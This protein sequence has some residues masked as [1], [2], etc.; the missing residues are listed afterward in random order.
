MRGGDGGGSHSSGL[1][2]SVP[3]ETDQENDIGGGDSS[4]GTVNTP[5]T[6]TAH[7]LLQL[8][9]DCLEQQKR[10][11]QQQQQGGEQ[12][13]QQQKQQHP[14]KEQQQQK[15]QQQH[16]YP[17]P[18]LADRSAISFGVR[19]AGGPL[20][21]SEGTETSPGDAAAGAFAVL[22]QRMNQTSGSGG[23]PRTGRG[24]GAAV[25]SSS[26][27]IGGNRQGQC[28]WTSVKKAA[29]KAA[30]T[31]TATEADVTGQAAANA[32]RTR[33]AGK[34]R[35]LALQV[36][37]SGTAGA[38]PATERVF[39]GRHVNLTNANLRGLVKLVSFQRS[40]E[41]CNSLCRRVVG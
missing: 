2:V 33:I 41:V 16:Q 22:D 26:S 32:A 19:G 35:R 28:D 15:Q 31:A 25:A 24:S 5:G 18:P 12:Q 23:R 30:A 4:A 27:A 38:G 21:G 11:Q 13:R 40:I 37:G 36:V 6:N 1:H 39:T 14:P 10:Q 8:R 17:K 7:L 34:K 9:R 20:R 3:P 29:T